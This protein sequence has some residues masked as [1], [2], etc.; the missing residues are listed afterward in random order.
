M[1]RRIA[2]KS[3]NLQAAE[4]AFALIKEHTS[5]QTS[6]VKEEISQNTHARRRRVVPHQLEAKGGA[7]ARTTRRSDL[8]VLKLGEECGRFGYAVLQHPADERHFGSG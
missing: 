3:I 6:V 7:A 4:Q 2:F 8:Q 1:S 5:N